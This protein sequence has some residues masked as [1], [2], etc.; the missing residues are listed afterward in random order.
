MR[1]RSPVALVTLISL[2]AAST[3]C[4]DFAGFTCTREVVAGELDTYHIVRVHAIFDDPTDRLLNIFDVTASLTQANALGSKAEF[5]QAQVDGAIPAS[6]LPLPFLPP[7]EAW[8]F[9]SYV[10]IGAEQGNLINGTIGDPG[11]DDATFVSNNAAGG[12]AGW[13]NLPPSNGFGVS[14][15][16]YGVLVGQFVVTATEWHD[17]LRLEF[18]ATVGYSN[19]GI[20]DFAAESRGFYYPDGTL[21]PYHPDRID[22]DLNSD[23]VF[24][25]PQARRIATWLMQGLDRKQGDVLPDVVPETFEAR[26]MG[27]LDGNGST[28]MVWRDSV[29][30]R[31]YA[32]LLESTT[33]SLKAPISIPLAPSWKVLGIGDISG[34]GRGDIVLRDKSTGEVHVWLMDGV[35]RLAEAQIATAI[36]LRIEGFGDFDGDAKSDILWRA[37]NGAMHV[38]LLDGLTV[39]TQGAVSNAPA[40]VA[41]SWRVVGTRDLDGD[42]NSDVVWQSPMGVAYIWLMDGLSK[43][44]G[45]AIAAAEGSEWRINGLRDLDGDGKYDIVWRNALTGDLHGW[46]M[47]GFTTKS[48]GFIRR[49]PIT[50]AV[51]EP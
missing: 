4:A 40:S 15:N 43:I 17:G 7:G 46:L 42:G 33:V 2:I 39:K 47:D 26:G 37:S 44:G 51:V 38:W 20:A 36:G 3:A 1:S 30:G 9:D 19:E 16:D 28:D 24:V 35:V 41:M 6:M 45:G 48:S 18:A 5:H 27:D 25:N 10:T 50:W 21:K 12:T 49:A 22:D 14:G 8:L 29:D 13:Y 11:F 23:V 32:W 31:F 34:D